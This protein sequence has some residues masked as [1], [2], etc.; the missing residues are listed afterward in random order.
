M[1]ISEI[2]PLHS[3][4]VAV[5]RLLERFDHQG[6]IIGGVAASVL[7]TPRLTADVDAV[8]LLSVSR[9]P[10]LLEVAAELNLVP[11]IPDVEQFARR[12]RVVLLPRHPSQLKLWPDLSSMAPPLV[13]LGRASCVSV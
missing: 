1:T 9:L 2:T 12:N 8:I 5:Q 7:G 3:P 6:V 10:K 13:R 11:R 4:L